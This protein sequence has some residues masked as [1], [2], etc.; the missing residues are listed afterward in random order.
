VTFDVHAFQTGQGWPVADLDPPAPGEPL[1]FACGGNMAVR[2]ADWREAGGFDPDLFAYFEDVEL[3]W[4]L[5]AA[6]RQIVA[7]PAAVARHRGAATSSGLGDFRRGVLFER[8]A[9]RIF[10]S[11]A[12]GD[13]REAF[14]AA[15]H[16]TFLHWMVAFAEGHPER[17][18]WVKDPFGNAEPPPGRRLRWRRRLVERGPRDTL[19]HA[20]ARLVLGPE[21]GSPRLGDG[22]LLMQLR[23]AQG[24]FAGI[25]S[26]ETRRRELQRRR[27]VP[28]REIV[29]RFPR[30][31]VPTYRG[32]EEWFASQAFRSLLPSGWPVEFAEL[33]EIIR[34]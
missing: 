19:R 12:D 34:P 8:N 7:A 17:A 16:A 22:H 9:L 1:P 29:A 27:S 10:H 11:C 14:G 3:G 18:E 4:R 25:D 28:D 5:W 2:S 30:L 21:A 15:V 20:A 32:D 24:F 26:C 31:V 33:T 23:A 13:C 6:G